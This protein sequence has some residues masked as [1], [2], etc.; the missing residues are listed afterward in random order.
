MKIQVVS[1]L[2][3]EMADFVLP[4]CE[5]D[6]VVLAGD[7]GVGLGGLEWIVGQG[8]NKPVVYVPGNHEFYEYDLSLISDLKSAA[9]PN[10]HVLNNDWIDIDGVRFVGSILW[11]DFQLFGEAD[12]YFAIQQAKK[13]MSDFYLIKIGDRKF[14]PYDAIELHEKSRSWLEAV[15]AEPYPGRTVVVTHHAPSS[16]SIH[17]RF[18]RNLLSPAFASNLE[19]MMGAERV[20]LWVHG[21]MHDLFDYDIYG[22]RVVCNPRGYASFE[23]MNNFCADLV[24]EI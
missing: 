22:T 4:D 9:P 10:V 21:H 16:A 2:H 14:T 11:T 19:S 8:I 17:P 24:V 1:D 7:I 6:V 12:K 18:A 20:A 13:D 15:L 23:F 3:I 5:A